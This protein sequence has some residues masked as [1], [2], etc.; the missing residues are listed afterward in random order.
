MLIR[1]VTLANPINKV[2][3]MPNYTL[4]IPYIVV[5][6]YTLVLSLLNAKNWLYPTIDRLD[7]PISIIIPIKLSAV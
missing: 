6:S 3:P 5:L 1:V 2:N 7:T 4:I